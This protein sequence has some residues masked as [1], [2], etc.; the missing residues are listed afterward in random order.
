[1]TVISRVKI[2]D[3]FDAI[4]NDRNCAR[5]CTKKEENYKLIYAPHLG[6]NKAAHLH[7]PD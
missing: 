4:A 7:N 5:K 1:M 2:L 3:D 6:Q